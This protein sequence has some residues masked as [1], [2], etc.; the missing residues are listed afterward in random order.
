MI[1]I[2]DPVRR[3]TRQLGELR[4][5]VAKNGRAAGAE[6]MENALTL[7]DSL[8]RDLAGIHLECDKLRGEVRRCSAAW[9]HLFEMMPSPCLL[10]DGA[11]EIVNANRAAGTVLNLSAK[12]LK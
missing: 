9:D 4:A 6:L 3:W 8:L 10:T 12:A 5:Q 1:K 7:C 11:G 2:A